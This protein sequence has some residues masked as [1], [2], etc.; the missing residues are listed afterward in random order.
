MWDRSPISL[1]CCEYPVV[2]A[3]LSESLFFSFWIV[4]H[5]C[6]KSTGPKFE[7]LFLDSELYSIDL[8]FYPYANITLSWLLYIWNQEVLSPPILLFFK[9]LLWLFQIILI[10][11]WIL[12]SVFQTLPSLRNK[13]RLGFDWNYVELI[14]QCVKN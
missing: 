2:L 14:D 5:S 6:W 8:Y 11:I 3:S 10:S 1:F 4:W 9:R 13:R 7:D 12:E